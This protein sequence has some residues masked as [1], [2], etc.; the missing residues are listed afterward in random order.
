MTII[1]VP[2]PGTASNTL[3]KKLEIIL[4]CKSKNLKTEAGIGHFFL[5]VPDNK[6][7]LKRLKLDFFDKSPLIYGH[8]FPTK[9]NLSLLNYYYGIEHIIISYRNIYEQLN[10]FYKWQ[11]YNL[12]C[13]F[14]FQDDVNFSNKNEFDSNNFNIDLSLLL[15]L[16]FYKHWFYLI[17]NNKINNFTLFNFEEITTCNKD[18]QKKI[19]NIFKNQIKFDNNVKE[20]LFKREKFEFHPRHKQLIEEFI[21]CHKEVDFSLII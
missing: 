17:Q 1:Y 9:R 10:Y 20:N 14:N 12:R 13:P 4:N 3:K 18:Y 15:V 16:N 7:I 2:A 5:N 6:K 11:K 19:K 21:S 8:F